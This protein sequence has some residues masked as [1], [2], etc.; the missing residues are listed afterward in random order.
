MFT[1]LYRHMFS[2]SNSKKNLNT[3]HLVGTHLMLRIESQ[4]HC[5]T[6]MWALSSSL[7]KYGMKCPTEVSCSTRKQLEEPNIIRVPMKHQLACWWGYKRWFSHLEHL[8][9]SRLRI[10]N[11]SHLIP[12]PKHKDTIEQRPR[13]HN[14]IRNVLSVNMQY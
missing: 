8:N 12:K 14:L 10:R 11:C 7:P 2:E 13:V 5:R 1:Y 9:H 3:S 4:Y 6:S